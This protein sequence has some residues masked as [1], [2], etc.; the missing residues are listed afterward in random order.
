MNKS[1]KLVLVSLSTALSF[2]LIMGLET[3]F[4]STPSANPPATNLT[5]TFSGLTVTGGFQ[6]MNGQIWGSLITN[7]DVLFKGPK[8]LIENLL[9]TQNLR[10]KTA[11]LGDTSINDI[12]INQEEII[13]PGDPLIIPFD[14]VLTKSSISFLGG[15]LESTFNKSGVVN[16]YNGLSLNSSNTIGLRGANIQLEGPSTVS[17]SLNVFGNATFS[18]K[19]KANSIGTYSTISGKTLTASSLNEQLD[20]SFSCP[21]GSVPINC[22]WQVN[23]GHNDRLWNIDTNYISYTTNSCVLKATNKYSGTNQIKYFATCFTPNL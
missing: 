23:S 22:G 9:E 12:I 14:V 19:I 16:A 18:G 17:G 13:V 1:K 6:S 10:A 3:V 15:S 5:P 20:L 7:S 11:T 21:T 8:V 4:S 2:V